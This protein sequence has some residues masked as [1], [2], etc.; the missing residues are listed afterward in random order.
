MAFVCKGAWTKCLGL[1][2]DDLCLPLLAKRLGHVCLYCDCLCQRNLITIDLSSQGCIN[3]AG[4]QSG[5]HLPH[6]CGICLNAVSDITRITKAPIPICRPAR[7][8][9]PQI[10]DLLVTS[11]L[12]QPQPGVLPGVT[13]ED[14]RASM[15]YAAPALSIYAAVAPEFASTLL[16]LS[17]C[18]RLPTTSLL[19]VNAEQVSRV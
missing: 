8:H 12:L 17:A 10:A 13:R 19:A 11:S 18:T 14:G 5:I 6:L 4:W 2:L 7:L 1:L 16:S 3:A 15:R 9:R